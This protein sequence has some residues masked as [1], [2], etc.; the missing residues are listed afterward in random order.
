[1]CFLLNEPDRIL[2][3]SRP[4][5]WAL[6]EDNKGLD[7]ISE[8]LGYQ[9]NNSPW[10]DLAWFFSKGRSRPGE[11]R[12]TKPSPY[13]RAYGSVTK[14]LSRRALLPRSLVLTVTKSFWNDSSPFPS[15]KWHISSC[16]R[17]I[18]LIFSSTFCSQK[19]S[20]NRVISVRWNL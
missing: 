18:S 4:R 9:R 6:R 10:I 11:G 3:K 1:M 12:R 13:R 8:I 20:S 14:V 5:T 7:Q 19:C 15:T 17:Q 16:H 2:A